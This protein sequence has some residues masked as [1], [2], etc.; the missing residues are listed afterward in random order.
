VTPEQ[1]L[2]A[3]SFFII[4]GHPMKSANNSEIPAG[5]HFAKPD[6]SDRHDLE[7]RITACLRDRLPG[8]RGDIHVTVIGST[9]AI[10]GTV[11]SLEDRRLC[12]E[13]CRH[14]PGVMR[15]VD[16]LIVE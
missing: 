3:H 7:W 16:D 2:P 6:T 5:I 15:V 4:E 14:V 11:R 9:A 12:L 8:L 1:S 13:C 10:R